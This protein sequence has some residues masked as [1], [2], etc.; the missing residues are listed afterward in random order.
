MWLVRSQDDLFWQTWHLQKK[1]CSGIETTKDW[2]QLFATHR[3][4]IRGAVGDQSI[5]L[6]ATL[7]NDASIQAWVVR[8]VTD[9]MRTAAK[10]SDYLLL[11]AL[12]AESARTRKEVIIGIARLP[13]EETI[14]L[15][16]KLSRNRVASPEVIDRLTNS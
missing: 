14:W 4:L 10:V 16:A 2:T 11:Q 1:L 9:D 8:A 5:P 15:T 7:A 12:K 6:L 3:D 13:I